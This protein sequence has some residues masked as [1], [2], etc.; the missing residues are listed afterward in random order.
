MRLGIPPRRLLGWEPTTTSWTDDDGVTESRPDP[1]W[2]WVDVAILAAWEALNERL[3][4]KCGRPLQLHGVQY[5][6]DFTAD[7]RE[8]PAVIALDAVQAERGALDDREVEAA[9]KRG[10]EV[11]ARRRPE[12]AR[13]WLTWTADEGEP[14]Y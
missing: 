1:E 2:D 13:T 8:C 12:R 5:P 14:D 4:D 7:Y 3:C 9:R 6:A 10:D 11:A